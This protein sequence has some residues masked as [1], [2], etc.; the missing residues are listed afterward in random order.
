MNKSKK[1]KSIL[2]MKYSI[3]NYFKP[4]LKYFKIII[5]TFSYS[6]KKRKYVFVNFV[7]NSSLLDL[8]TVDNAISAFW[9]WII[10]AIG[11]SHALDFETTNT[12]FNSFFTQKLFWLYTLF[13]FQE[14]WWLGIFSRNKIIF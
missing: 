14:C 10:I 8:I 4:I 1:W 3:D 5:K 2:Q 9:K 6:I 11:Y 12:F 13:V 7:R